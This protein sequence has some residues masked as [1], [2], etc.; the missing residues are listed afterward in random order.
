[1]VNIHFK[2]L[3]AKAKPT[4]KSNIVNPVKMSRAQGIV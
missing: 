1:M 4:L 3:K 2:K